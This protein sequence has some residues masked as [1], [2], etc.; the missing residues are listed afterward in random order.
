VLKDGRGSKVLTEPV[1]AWL[2]GPACQTL[3]NACFS[4][5]SSY[6]PQLSP[7]RL[8]DKPPFSILTFPTAGD[9]EEPHESLVKLLAA[10]GEH[11][12]DYLALS[13]A[14]P[15]VQAFLG[16]VLGFAGLEGFF[17]QDEEVS[18]LVVPFWSDFQEALTASPFVALLS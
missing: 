10:L 4:S 13:L 6:H 1:L 18:D 9:V 14:E 16:L 2:A 5:L 15:D 17:G 8:T 7:P 12:A 11:S 3:A